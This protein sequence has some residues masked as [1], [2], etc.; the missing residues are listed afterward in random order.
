A[1]AD[2]AK[3]PA[4][5]YV[6][7]APV[8]ALHAALAS[9]LKQVRGWLDDGD[10]ASA[11]QT[12]QGLAALA[13]LHG[14]QGGEAWRGKTATLRDACTGLSTALRRKDAAASDRAMRACSDALAELAKMKLAAATVPVK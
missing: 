2:V 7:V 9:N 12:A 4:A 11:E 1:G 10:F 14:F 3:A 8:S 5:G 13:W 6:P